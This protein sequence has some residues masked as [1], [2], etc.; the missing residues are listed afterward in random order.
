MDVEFALRS[1]LVIEMIDL[2]KRTSEE[3][4]SIKM[5]E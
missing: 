1:G 4:I 5:L 3:L 2:V